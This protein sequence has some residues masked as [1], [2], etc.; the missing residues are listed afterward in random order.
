[1][2]CIR[3]SILWLVVFSVCAV[4]AATAGENEANSSKTENSGKVPITTRSA[5]ARNLYL[6]AMVKMQNLHGQQAMHHHGV[7]HS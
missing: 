6:Q 3:K 7:P 1:M 4:P 5:E 2:N